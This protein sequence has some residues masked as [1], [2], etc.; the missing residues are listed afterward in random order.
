M[1]DATDIEL[2]IVKAAGARFPSGE[3]GALQRRGV[4]R[5]PK[6]R[7][8]PSAVKAAPK[9]GARTWPGNFWRGGNEHVLLDVRVQVG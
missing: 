8:R 2:R 7:S 9:L 5:L 6:R 1:D 3:P 4:Q